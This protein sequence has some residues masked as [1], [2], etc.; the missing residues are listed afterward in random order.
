MTTT[1]LSDNE[2][3][4]IAWC[5]AYFPPM[6]DAG[7]EWIVDCMRERGRVLTGRL[8]HWCQKWD[9]LTIDE[10]C[11]EWPCGCFPELEE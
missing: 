10:T 5:R 11:P 3:A 2:L 1:P 4:S 7:D 6:D 8:W 9:F